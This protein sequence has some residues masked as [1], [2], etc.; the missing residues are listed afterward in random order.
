M[1]RLLCAV[2]GPSPLFAGRVVPMNAFLGTLVKRC[3]R[4]GSM[5]ENISSRPA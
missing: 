5:I 3:L 4:W 1:R 2:L